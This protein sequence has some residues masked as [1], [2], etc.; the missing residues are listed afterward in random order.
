M[1]AIPAVP[2]VRI[3]HIEDK[4]D[5]QAIIKRAITKFLDSRIEVVAAASFK[6]CKELLEEDSNFS[7]VISDWVLED[8]T[9]D[10]I[11]EYIQI[12]YPALIP[13]YMFLCSQHYE[14]DILCEKYGLPFLEKPCHPIQ[15]R[16]TIQKILDR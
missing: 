11:F 14:A 7:V 13:N 15:I 12:N 1:P 4:P 10:R 16:T 9:G 2:A 3:L 6:A 5:I 8:S